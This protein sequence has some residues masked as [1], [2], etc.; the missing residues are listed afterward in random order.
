MDPLYKEIIIVLTSIFLGLALVGFVLTRNFITPQRQDQE[1]SDNDNEMGNVLEKPLPSTASKETSEWRVVIERLDVIENRLKQLE[2]QK[3]QRKV[4][5]LVF[6][7]LL[8]VIA[9]GAPFLYISLM[10]AQK[11]PQ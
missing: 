7:I 4:L 1:D 2:D 9:I 3:S 11:I 6:S 10:I 5:G 8:P